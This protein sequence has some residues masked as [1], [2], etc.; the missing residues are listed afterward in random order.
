MSGKNEGTEAPT[1]KRLKEARQEGR[2]ARTPDLSAWVVVGACV[3]QVPGA[4]E[5]GRAGL[6]RLLVDLRQ[7]IAEP[8]QAQVWAALSHAGETVATVLLPLLAACIV[9]A[10]VSGYLQGGLRLAT[11]AAKPKAS[12]LN[13]I[14]GAKRVFGPQ[15]AWEGTKV[16]IKV[17]V[18]AVVMYT[19]VKGLAPQLTTA[20]L[21]PLASTLDT[22]QGAVGRLVTTAA[23]AG[24]VVA[25]VDYA[26]ARRR[27]LKQLRMTVREVKDEHRQSEGDPMLKGAIRA[28]Q[29]AM[30]RNRM[31]ADVARA[32]VVLVNPTHVA[33]ALR[34]EPESGAP[35]VVAKGKGHVARRIREL[36]AENRVP[37]VADVPL[38]RALHDAC[39]VGQ[40]VPAQVYA[41]VARVLAFVMALRARGSAAGV[42][43]LPGQ[44]APSLL[45]SAG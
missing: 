1:P 32:D 34:Y 44:P 25:G 27:I 19:V 43:R 30:S 22:A 21:L 9:G 10:V 2:V 40:E 41:A 13:P 6:D 16:L 31:M 23:V 11:K 8:E 4:V 26:V 3:S 18:L 33:V 24:L 36:A 14:A 39:E 7:T 35:R 15:A 5:R 38:A 12:H 45:K 28:R 20:G 37:M 29:I 17:A 42:H